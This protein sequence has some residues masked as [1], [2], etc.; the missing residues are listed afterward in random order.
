MSWIVTDSA[1][2]R[3][4]LETFSPKVAAAINR[5]RYTVQ[6]AGEYLA[7]LNARARAAALEQA[8]QRV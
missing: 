5:D 6:E 2:G 1:T 7:Q 8:C 4:V 3:A